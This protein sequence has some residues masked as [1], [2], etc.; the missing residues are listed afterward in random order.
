ME[1]QE[2]EQEEEQEA[3]LSGLGHFLTVIVTVKI[4]PSLLR[5]ASHVESWAIRNRAVFLEMEVFQF[6]L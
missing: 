1:G 5:N 3:N 6:I 4:C 2:E